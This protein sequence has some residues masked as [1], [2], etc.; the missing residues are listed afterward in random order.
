MAKVK[1][2]EEVT[3]TQKTLK[4]VLTIIGIILGI[5]FVAPFLIILINSFKTKKE[6]FTSVLALPQEISKGFENY[7]T[8][9]ERLDFVRSFGTSLFITACS[10]ILIIICTSMAAWMLQRTKSKVSD[11]IL[12]LMVVSMLIPFQAVMLPLVRI[13]GKIGFLNQYGLIFMYLGFQGAMSTFL[14]H[15]FVKNIP[16]DLDEAAV[17]DGCNTF[18]TFWFI[19][20][21]LLKPI[22]VTVAILN[23]VAIWND[24]LL[25]SLV[26]GGKTETIPLKTFLFFGEY[27]K[28]WHLALAGLVITILPVLIFYFF[29]QKQVL[30]SMVEGSVK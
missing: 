8:A 27:T 23:L 15:G 4:V 26:I 2:S 19:I 12:M 1:Y 3:K 5:G 6:L 14:Y 25:P 18:Q 22:T 10:I 16:R 7:K 9:F 29:A 20:F 24:Y 11:F 13:M 28:Q 17:I 21:P 30:S